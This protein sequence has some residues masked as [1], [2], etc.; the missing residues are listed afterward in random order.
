MMGF[1]E[2]LHHIQL[3]IAMKKAKGSNINAHHDQFRIL[4]KATAPKAFED[5]I[6]R[7]IKS[8]EKERTD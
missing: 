8:T 6:S 5:S 2:W 1:Q 4:H 3:L 7:N